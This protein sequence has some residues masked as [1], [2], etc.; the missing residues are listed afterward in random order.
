MKKNNRVGLCASAVLMACSSACH[1]AYA[2]MAEMMA[3]QNRAPIGVM[4]AHMHNQGEWMMSY[5]FM[6][7][8]MSGMLRGDQEISAEDVATQIANPYANP[9]M[10]PPTVRV[11]PEKMTSQMHMIGLMYSPSDDLT[12]M[13]MLNYLDKSMDLTTFS[14]GMGDTQLGSFTTQSSGLTDSSIGGLY[15]LFSGDTHHLHVNVNWLVPIGDI[16]ASDDVLTPMNMRMPMRLPYGMQLGTGSHQLQ[17][18]LTYAGKVDNMS[19]GAQGLYTSVINDNDEDYRWGDSAQLSTWYG[20]RLSKKLSASLRLTYRHQQDIDG[21]DALIMA[22]VTTANPNNYGF[23]RIDLGL[24]IN[25]VI[26]HGHRAALE[27]ELPLYEDVNGVQMAMDS[28]LT[29]GY[30]YMF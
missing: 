7:M 2:N 15:R 21:F 28:M 1:S 3:P 19:W 29:L 12:L 23:E 13:A 11:V 17:A 10:S 25:T 27:W 18:G 22:P 8:D 26:S 16:E 24:G 20:Y 6:H 4:G 14:G 30:Q 5:R 9:P